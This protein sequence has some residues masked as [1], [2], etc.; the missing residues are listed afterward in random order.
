MDFKPGQIGWFDISVPDAES[1]KDFYCRVV[2]W[3]AEPVEMDG[4]NDHCVTPEES[5]EP[6][7]GICHAR[8]GNADLPP[9][10]LIY[11][12]VADLEESLRRVTELG[13]SAITPIREYGSGRYA[14][15]RDPTGA[16]C[17][18]FQSGPA[19]AD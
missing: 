4:Y 11:I 1:L 16:A 7:G 13:G 14:V 3:K 2:G 8:G 12:T 18:L 19:G 10:W 9:Q 15:I 17:A 5:D 6:V